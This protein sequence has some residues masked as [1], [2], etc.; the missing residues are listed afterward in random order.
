MKKILDAIKTEKRIP[1]YAPLV[2]VYAMALSI[3][4]F[5]DSPA[6]VVQRQP[7]A[8]TIAQVLAKPGCT[9]DERRI[10]R[11]FS[12]D[13]LPGLMQKGLV[14]KFVRNASGTLILVNGTLWRARS[15]FFKQSLLTEVFTFNKVNEC[16]LTTDVVDVKSGKLYARV[17]PSAQMSFYD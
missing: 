2:M 3:V 1:L 7:A 9:E 12:A 8:A 5:V 17:S 16:E 6:P 10:A 14:Q 4:W 11:R 15:K 13:T